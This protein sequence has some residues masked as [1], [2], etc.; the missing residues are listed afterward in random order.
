[1]GIN[2]SYFGHTPFIV[3]FLPADFLCLIN[4]SIPFLPIW[5]PLMTSDQKVRVRLLE[6]PDHLHAY[7]KHFCV[8]CH[9]M[10][11]DRPSPIDLQPRRIYTAYLQTVTG[12]SSFHF[13][14]S[15]PQQ[16]PCSTSAKTVLSF[17]P[18]RKPLFSY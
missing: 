7:E 12:A 14:S 3:Y 8:V 16:H 6:F 13:G 2:L 15:I 18:A 11:H 9:D 10:A 4:Q 17:T 1:M 5:S